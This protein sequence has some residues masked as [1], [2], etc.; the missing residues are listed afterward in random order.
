VKSILALTLLVGCGGATWQQP[1]PSSPS[2]QTTAS[3]PDGKATRWTLASI[4]CFTNGV[5]DDLQGGK[6]DPCA[7]LAV[8]AIGAAST[9]ASSRA[10]VRAIDPRAVASIVKAIDA[11]TL[12]PQSGILVRTV[13]DASREAMVARQAAERVR[14]FGWSDA[15]DTV[16]FAHASLRQLSALKSRTASIVTL[17]L[18]AD[19][20]ENVR[21]LPPRAKLAAAAPTFSVVFGISRPVETVPGTW[22]AYV[23]DAARAAGHEAPSKGNTHEREQAAFAGVAAGLADRLELA[24]KTAEGEVSAVASAYA[25]RL[26]SAV[27]EQTKNARAKAAAK[28]SAESSAN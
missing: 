13:A 14:T 28:P 10:A 18:A 9:D 3:S 23:S 11:S 17:V 15:D 25:K 19:R 1:A 24:A 8:E 4:A 20:L 26:G 21:G 5:W 22:L 12:D 6:P 2:Q 16:L 7:L 27:A